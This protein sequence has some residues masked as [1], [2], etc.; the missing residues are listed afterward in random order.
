M[1]DRQTAWTTLPC[2]CVMPYC[3]IRRAW[4]AGPYPTAAAA[5]EVVPRARRWA[6][7][8]SGDAQAASYRYEV[9][10]HFDGETRSILGELLP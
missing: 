5:H 2:Y 10:Q 4:L 3:T 8:Q 6:L 1:F 7:R 9:Y